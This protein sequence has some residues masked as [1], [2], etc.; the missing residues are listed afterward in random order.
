M[1]WTDDF[2]YL[3]QPVGMQ[4]GAEGSSPQLLANYIDAH[5]ENHFPDLDGID[6]VILGVNESRRSDS[7][8][9]QRGA[10]AIREK[11]YALY[12]HGPDIKIADVGNIDAGETPHDTDHA[13]KTVVKN[14]VD[15]NIAVIILGGSQELT[16]SNYAAYEVLESTVNLAVIDSSIDLGEFREELSPSNY[17]SKIVLHDPSYLFNLSVLGYQTYLSEPE[18]INLIEKLFFD[19]HRLGT[20]AG[21]LKTTEPLLRNA[22]IVSFDINSIQNSSAPGTGQPNGFSG[23]QACQMARYAGISDKTTSI[24]FYNYDVAKDTL[25]QTAMLIAQMVWCAIDG[26]CY[27]QRE[28]P[29]FSKKNFLEYKVHLPDGKDEMIF[30]KSKRTDKWW[31][32]V[33]YAGGDQGRLSRHHLVPCS[34]SDYEQAGRGDVPDMWWRTYQKLG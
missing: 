9:I 32:N 2:A 12:Q 26:F 29:L 28:F 14:L 13:V 10:D 8:T 5:R 25:G 27:R 20:L 7:V 4:P 19:A 34:Y 24:G 23:E 15:R 17:L 16:F 6:L 21:D 31:M 22:D 18:S 3:L 1:N 11:L 33:P 30:Y